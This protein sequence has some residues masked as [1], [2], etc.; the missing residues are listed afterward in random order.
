MPV[1]IID[2]SGKVLQMKIRGMLKKADL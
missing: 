2:V 1:E